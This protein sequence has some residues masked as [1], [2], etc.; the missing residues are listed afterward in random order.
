MQ[1]IIYELNS[2]YKEVIIMFE[3]FRKKLLDAID[4]IKTDKN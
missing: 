2:D 1:A 3:P 4:L